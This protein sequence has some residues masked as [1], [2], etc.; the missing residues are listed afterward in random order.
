VNLS[1]KAV[2]YWMNQERITLENTIVVLDDVALPFGKLR[3]RAGE[4]TEDTT[5]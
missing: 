4:V 3:L 1:G 5:G 2:R